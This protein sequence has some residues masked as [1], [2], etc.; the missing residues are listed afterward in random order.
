MMHDAGIESVICLDTNFGYVKEV[1]DRAGL[2]RVIVTNLVDLIPWWKRMLGH[3]LD[4]IPM[5]NS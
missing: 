1:M 2:K 3:M 4:K 5:G